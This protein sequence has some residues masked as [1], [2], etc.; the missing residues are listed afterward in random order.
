[1][2]ARTSISTLAAVG[3]L[4]LSMHANAIV[5][6][7][8]N[9]DDAI[10]GGV[11]GDPIAG[12]LMSAFTNMIGVL[13]STVFFHSPSGI[14]TYAFLVEPNIDNISEFNSVFPVNALVNDGTEV[15]FSFSDALAAGGT[16]TAADFSINLDPDGT[17][18]YETVGD[19]FGDTDS[20]LFHFRSTAGPTDGQYNMINSHVGTADGFVPVPLPSVIWL[21]GSALMGL[22][23]LRRQ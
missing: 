11:I 13:T 23:V 1:M 12:P 9:T 17:L 7:P 19:F 20:I 8:F 14:Y 18:D 2:K 10:A 6:T 15:G 22:A 21:F 5:L 4:S 3:L 16:G